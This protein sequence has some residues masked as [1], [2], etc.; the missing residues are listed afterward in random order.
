[1]AIVRTKWQWSMLG[2]FLAFLAL[3]PYLLSW[4]GNVSWLTFLNFTLITIVAVLGLNIITG[5]AGQISLGHSA[6]V[7][8]GAY[9]VAI[10]MM[11]GNLPFW[12]ALPVSSLITAVAGILVGAPSLRLKGFYLAVATFAFFFIAQYIIRNLEI[13]GG[14]VGLIGMP[15]VKIGDLRIKTDT[16]WY[17]LI[18]VVTIAAV[19]LS[20]NLTRSRLGR[21]FL[22]LRDND[23]TAASMG[24]NI[25]LTKLRAFFIG[26][27][28]A[29]IAGS[30]WACYITVVTP[31][32]FNIWDSIWYLG[33]IVIGGGGSTA[34]AVLG[35]VFLRFISQGLHVISTASWA[36]PLSSSTWIST[37]FAIYG[38]IIVLFVSFQPYGLISVWRKIKIH[39]KRWPFGY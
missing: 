10:L 28:F 14:S 36:P 6:F 26:S 15:P 25:Y 13:A 35:V 38:L 34:G 5:M 20:A 8:V 21:A 4:T 3:L 32:Q 39:Y 18:L 37:T 1:M 7:M 16:D 17:Y 31:E 2:I 27:L 22:A 11:K 24:I 29:G 9:A 19:I 12:L 30:L 33:M 23:I